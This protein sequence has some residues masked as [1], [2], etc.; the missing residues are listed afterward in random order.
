MALGVEV[1]VPFLDNEM[2]NLSS[3]IPINFKQRRLTSKWILKKAM[4]NL[5]PQ[6]IINRPKTGFGLPLKRWIKNDLR[7]LISDL[8]SSKSIKSR[9]I[10][11]PYEVSKLIESNDKGLIDASYTIFSLLCIELWCR[12][13]IDNQ[14]S[15]FNSF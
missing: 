13:Y 12:Y 7:D 6:N 3:Q 9:D 5:L 15:N 10:F 11:D 1:R 2:L 14:N 8:L 4:K